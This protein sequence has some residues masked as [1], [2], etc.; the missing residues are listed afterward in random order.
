[1]INAY[2]QLATNP[3]YEVHMQYSTDDYGFVVRNRA[4]PAM[5]QTA[6]KTPKDACLHL[7]FIAPSGYEIAACDLRRTGDMFACIWQ[8]DSTKD[9]RFFADLSDAHRFTVTRP[10]YDQESRPI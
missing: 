3:I 8:R 7:A 1:M 5:L 10:G 4:L 9:H 6:M 2:L